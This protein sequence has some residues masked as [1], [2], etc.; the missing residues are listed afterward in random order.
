MIEIRTPLRTIFEGLHLPECPRWRNGRLYFS[1]MYGQAV[2]AVSET[3]E[4]EQ[5]CTV[6]GRPGG[7]GF[8]ENGDLLINEME[9]ARVLRLTPEGD[10]SIHA[11]LT[12]LVPSIND[13]ATT[14]DGRCYIGKLTM[15]P[16]FDAA[17]LITV[18]LQGQP[19]IA[20]NEKLLV[21]NGMIVR[22]DGKTLIVAESAAG[23]LIAYDIDAQGQL[24]N[25]RVFAQLPKELFPDGICGDNEGG[26]WL[27]SPNSGRFARVLEG[28]TITHQ[29]SLVPGRYA[30]SCALG[31]KTGRTLF[32]CTS[33][34][35]APET[36]SNNT[37]GRIETVEVSVAG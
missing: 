17:P 24:S 10:L 4:S 15:E 26:I 6:P 12:A 33:G 18:D 1:D 20:T 9:T 7:L 28:G 3:G 32:M 19:S 31:G 16:P 14:A 23:K 27:A 34:H 36:V 35:Y 5:L 21:A 22:P 30:Y 8:A 13:M 11:D 25:H 37:D 2:Y 29:I